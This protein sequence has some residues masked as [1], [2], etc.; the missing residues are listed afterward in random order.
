MDPLSHP[1]A[2][3][4]ESALGPDL[5]LWLTLVRQSTRING[6]VLELDRQLQRLGEKAMDVD[7]VLRDVVDRH[8]EARTLLSEIFGDCLDLASTTRDE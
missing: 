1:K 6:R 7:V 4:L 3:E 5:E 8:P 2:E